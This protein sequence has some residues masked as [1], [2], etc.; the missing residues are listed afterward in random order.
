LTTFQLIF[1]NIL[2]IFVTFFFISVVIA[3]CGNKY[4]GS[5]FISAVPISLLI[6]PGLRTIQFLFQ[7]EEYNVEEKCPTRHLVE[8][9]HQVVEQFQLGEKTQAVLRGALTLRIG[10]LPHAA[11]RLHV[12]AESCHEQF[13]FQLKQY[14]ESQELPVY[15]SIGLRFDVYFSLLIAIIN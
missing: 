4:Y 12:L 8:K 6:A 1:D 7:V 11:L 15:F 10:L 14:K 13:R 3:S 5:N 2:T 9:Q